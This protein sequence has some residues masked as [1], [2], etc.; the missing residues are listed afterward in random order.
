MLT[1][2]LHISPLFSLKFSASETC[3]CYSSLVG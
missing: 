1:A 2:E 3:L